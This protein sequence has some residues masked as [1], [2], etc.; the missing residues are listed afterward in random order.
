M[1]KKKSIFLV[2]TEILRLLQSI[3]T[4]R[5]TYKLSKEVTWRIKKTP[6]ES[7]K[8]NIYIDIKELEW[9]ILDKVTSVCQND[10]DV[11]MK[12]EHKLQQTLLYWI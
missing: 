11:D 9:S 10:S 7:E 3:I 12:T 1:N 2:A 8:I 5:A 4:R 6:R